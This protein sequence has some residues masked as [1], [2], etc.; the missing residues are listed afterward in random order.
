MTQMSYARYD[1]GASS[2]PCVHRSSGRAGL[3]SGLADDLTGN[4]VGGRMTD[5][6][7]ETLIDAYGSP[8]RLPD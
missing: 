1:T 8:R 2:T 5:E 6:M 3:E 7:I 4:S